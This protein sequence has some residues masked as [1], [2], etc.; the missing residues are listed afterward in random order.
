MVSLSC[1]AWPRHN[2]LVDY[3][4][5][6]VFRQENELNDPNGGDGPSVRLRG[7]ERPVTRRCDGLVS[8]VSV[9]PVSSAFS[10]C[11]RHA[12]LGVDVQL[13]RDHGSHPNSRTDSRRNIGLHLPARHRGSAARSRFVRGRG[14]RG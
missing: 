10:G 12:S 8:Q 7:H 3:S 5:L 2:R 9:E 6:I 11:V 4:L 1:G 13:H 14:W